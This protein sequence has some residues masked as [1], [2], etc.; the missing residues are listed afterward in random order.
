MLICV[1][2]RAHI[3]LPD[4]L[5]EEVDEIAGPRKRSQFI[6]E[7][8]RIKLLNERQKRALALPGPTL[9]PKKYPHWATP[10][11]TTEW[12]HDLR[13]ADQAYTDARRANRRRER[14]RKA[15]SGE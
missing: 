12:V 5:V 11:L 13:R 7:A 6:E 3:S 10:E 15:A 9:D 2:M 4:D 8:V 1:P 14:D